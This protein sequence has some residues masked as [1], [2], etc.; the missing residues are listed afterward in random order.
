MAV[1]RIIDAGAVATPWRRLR[2]DRGLRAVHPSR[3]ATLRTIMTGPLPTDVQAQECTV[4]VL[5]RS[6]VALNYLTGGARDMTFS[7][8]CHRA[9]RTKR[10]RIARAGWHALAMAIDASCGVLRGECEHC[11]TAWTNHIT[12]PRARA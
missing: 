4:A 10:S 6:S 7:A 11:A 8:R 9:R 5:F 1:L 3:L 12:R 2:R